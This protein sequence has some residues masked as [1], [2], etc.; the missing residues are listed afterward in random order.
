MSA[1]RVL[2]HR[3]EE[4][5]RLHRMGTGAREAAR[6]LGM[7]PNTERQYRLALVAEGLWAGPVDALPS[8]EALKAAVVKHLPSAP[9]PEAQQSQIE[10]WREHIKKLL[11]NPPPR[12]S[13]RSAAPRRILHSRCSSFT[14]PTSGFPRAQVRVPRSP[15]LGSPE[16]MPGFPTTRS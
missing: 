3:L 6:L 14:E 13:A 11:A 1:R 7:S 10:P 8:L 5:V 4:L 9:V 15:G 12:S 16:P 2:M